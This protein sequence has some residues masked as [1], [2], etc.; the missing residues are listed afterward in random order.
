MDFKTSQHRSLQSRSHPKPARIHRKQGRRHPEQ[1]RRDPQ[2]EFR[3][4]K[5]L[6]T[7]RN[8]PNPSRNSRFSEAH[9]RFPDAQPEVFIVAS[10]L[11]TKT[12]RI[13]RQHARFRC[14]T[15]NL[16]RCSRKHISNELFRSSNTG[17]EPTTVRISLPSGSIAPISS[18]TFTHLTTSRRD[19]SL[20]TAMANGLQASCPHAATRMLHRLTPDQVTRRTA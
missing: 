3:P 15:P 7:S 20:E 17:S 9:R 5:T 14:R 11:P 6:A 12:R 10:H 16:Q 1:A 18:P 8:G 2:H 13:E 19:F 4:S